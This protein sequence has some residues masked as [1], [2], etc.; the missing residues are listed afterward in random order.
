MNEERSLDC[1]LSGG[2][3]YCD[4]WPRLAYSV[5]KLPEWFWWKNS[6]ALKRLKFE[7]AEGRAVSDDLRP[8]LRKVRHSAC[9]PRIFG[10]FC[11]RLQNHV[12]LEN[13]FFNRIGR[14]QPLRSLEQEEAGKKTP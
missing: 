6:R 11:I 9:L 4:D 2:P 10:H 8:Q 7:R 12:R 1:R 3:L 14:I 5:E 13:E